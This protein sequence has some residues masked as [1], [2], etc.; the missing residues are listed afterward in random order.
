VAVVSAFLVPGNPLPYLKPQVAG[1]SA[2]SSAMRQAG[3]AIKHSRPDTVLVYSTQWIAVLDE[4]WLTRVRSTGVHV[5]ENWYEFG[6]LP[7]DIYSD[8]AL[9]KACVEACPS[10]GVKA[11]GVDYDAFPIDTGTITAANLMG[12]GTR[13]LPLVVAANNVYHDAGT[14][15]KLAALAVECASKADKRVAV[16]AV[17]GLSGSLIRDEIDLKEDHIAEADDDARNRQL[18]KLI[19]SGDEKGLKAY[20]PEFAAKARAD[21][22]LKHLH[23]ILGALGGRHRGARVHHYG[24]LY[25]SGGA[26]VEFVL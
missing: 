22:G 19:E 7:Y 24:P 10:V 1:L 15:E 26:V 14:T 13:T 18:L 6:D 9:A 8:T 12:L 17:G 20:L 5:D 2:F 16:L 4:L 21:M 11:R 23:W 25:G 3:E